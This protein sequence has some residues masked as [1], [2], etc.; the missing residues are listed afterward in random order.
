M[1]G[2]DPEELM[3]W[4]LR[5]EE[6]LG[7]TET[8][9]MIAD[10][11]L[12]KERLAEELGYIP[13]DAQVEALQQAGLLA[14]ERMPEIGIHFERIPIRK[15]RPELGLRPAYRDIA[16]GEFAAKEDVWA[17]IGLL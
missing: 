17:A 16:T 12:M 13:S 1:A 9:R 15:A 14:Y 10:I 4:L 5:E 2:T 6:I 8:E 3:E 7:A 11:E